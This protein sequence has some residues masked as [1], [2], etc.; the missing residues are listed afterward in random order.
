MV[1][2]GVGVMTDVVAPVFQAY[3]VPPEAV[4][5]A[6]DPAHTDPSLEMPDVSVTAMEDVGIVF[7]V[8]VVVAVDVQPLAP[9]TVTV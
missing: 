6:D 9:V 5:V 7:I 3:D 8:M 1:T 2:L 4:N